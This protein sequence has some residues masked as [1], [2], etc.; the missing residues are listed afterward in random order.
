[1]LLGD[2]ESDSEFARLS[3]I[4]GKVMLLEGDIGEADKVVV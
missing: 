1:M 2:V 3:S 4:F